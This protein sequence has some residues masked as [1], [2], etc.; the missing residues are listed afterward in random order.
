MC[1]QRQHTNSLGEDILIQLWC[2]E[3]GA[4]LSS[5]PCADN[6]LGQP[7]YDSG[8]PCAGLNTPVGSYLRQGAVGQEIA[9]KRSQMAAPAVV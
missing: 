8:T 6:Y 2:S 1:T 4:L 3:P 9:A 5:W 7:G